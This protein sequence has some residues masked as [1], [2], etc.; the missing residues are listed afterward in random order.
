V[1]TLNARASIFASANPVESRYNPKLSVVENIQ[2]PPTLLSRFDLI[3]LILD[4]A[5]RDADRRLAKHI[6]A[7]YEEH[8]PKSEALVDERFVRDYVAYARARVHPELSDE[9]RTELI[10]AYVRMRG[11]GAGRPNRGRSITATPRQ[12][13]GMIRISEALARIRLE[14]VVLRA[15][16]LEAVRLMQVATLAAATDSTTGLIDM[17]A[18]NTGRTA[19]DREQLKNLCAELRALVD[20]HPRGVPVPVGDLRE[21][22]QA[23][24]DGDLDQVFFFFSAFFFDGS[25][26]R[27]RS[28]SARSR[29]SPRTRS[30]CTTSLAPAS[31]D[32]GDFGTLGLLFFSRDFTRR[33]ARRRARTVTRR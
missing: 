29:P 33:R 22:M 19:L 6:V 24:T 31:A 21:E 18:I 32:F 4:H 15:D 27:R 3:Y 8:P 10:E 28:S 13:E 1:A 2:L 11:G 30:S 20:L 16:V 5:D 25:R 23:Q 9:A 12:L 17:D 26:A 7:L 14:S